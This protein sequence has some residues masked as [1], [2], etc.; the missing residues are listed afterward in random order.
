MFPNTERF[1][2]SVVDAG[3]ADQAYQLF[4]QHSLHLVDLACLQ[5][6]ARQ[7]LVI[8]PAYHNKQSQSQGKS[9]QSWTRCGPVTS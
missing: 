4:Q 2:T 6:Q 3:N 9:S 8:H 1:F 5:T 7:H